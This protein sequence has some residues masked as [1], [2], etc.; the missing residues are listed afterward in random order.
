MSL[1]GNLQLKYKF[2]MVNV[3]SFIGMCI[4][5]ASFVM[6]NGIE[7]FSITM[8]V[9]LALMICMVMLASQFLI[10]YVAR[11]ITSI[12]NSMKEVQ[13][14]G[15]LSIRVPVNSND[16]IGAMGASFNNMQQSLHDIVQQVSDA[17]SAIQGDSNT[18]SIC[19]SEASNGIQQQQQETN[20]MANATDNMV[21]SLENINE[22]A[23]SGENSALEAS[24]LADN[25][26][27]AVIEVSESINE[28]ASEVSEASTQIT[29]LVRH[30]DEITNILEVIRGIAD[31]TNLLALNAAIEAARAGEQGRGF[32]VV[33]D[34]VRV[35]AKRTQGSTEEIQTMVTSLQTA[36]SKAVKVMEKGQQ[37]AEESTERAN[38]AASALDEINQSVGNICQ[39]NTQIYHMT[40]E[41]R[42]ATGTIQGNMGNIRSVIENTAE[43]MNKSN[44]SCDS[45]HQLAEELS[46]KIHH[47]KL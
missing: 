18:M 45:L 34:E 23:K 14:K 15:D 38:K 16:E 9:V 29:E 10:N 7:S 28:L 40:E 31:Q 41:Q 36:T 17:V 21:T 35:L 13:S 6:I 42:S 12:S 47:F 25:G 44:Q 5:L 39:L 22:N 8:L 43:G 20:Q 3:V 33:A 37:S 2:W 27:Q 32:A 46:R 26:R 11:P 4:L 19:V 30:S 1:L 24:Q